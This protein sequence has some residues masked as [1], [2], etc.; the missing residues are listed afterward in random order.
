M[1][2]A[3]VDPY[4]VSFT[5]RLCRRSRPRPRRPRAGCGLGHPGHRGRAPH[6][7][8]PL[9]G[10]AFGVFR[11][12]TGHLQLCADG[13]LGGRF[14]AFTDLDRGDWVGASGEV[15]ST[16]RGELS[17]RVAEFSL[18]AKAL[19]PLP[20]KWHGLVD[21]EMRHRRRY[22]DLIVNP[23]A[24]L[25]MARRIRRAARSGVPS[26]PRVSRSR[27]PDAPSPLGRPGHAIRHPPRRAR[28]R[29]VPAHRAGAVPEASGGRRGRPGLRDRPDVPQR[30]GL[31]PAQPRVH[32][33]R[34]L[35]G[36][37]RLRRH[38]E[39]TEA[40]VVAAAR[41]WSAPPKWCTGRPMSLR[42]AV[43]AGRLSRPRSRP[44]GPWDHR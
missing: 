18:L 20:D 32:D 23:Q 12:P 11:D 29:H 36:A 44:P 38:V 35:S 21:V 22:V 42:A 7:A 2:A 37:R 43:A 1:R 14:D 34:G 25:V 4:P 16:R 9:G 39:L 31:P 30:G 13:A 24:R 19:R 41:G 26:R 33:A 40:L 3:G 15:M 28:H 8:S 17:V 5:A 6:D 27:D 10:L